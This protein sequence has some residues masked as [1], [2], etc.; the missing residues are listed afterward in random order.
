M[1]IILLNLDLICFLTDKFFRN[2]LSFPVLA[3]IG[4]HIASDDSGSY[5][6]AKKTNLVI[7]CSVILCIVTRGFNTISTAFSA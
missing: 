1:E 5:Y 4:W 7:I 2:N 6:L 3:L